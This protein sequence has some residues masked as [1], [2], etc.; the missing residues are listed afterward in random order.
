MFSSMAELADLG[1]TMAC[2][3][4]IDWR[5]TAEHAASKVRAIPPDM[6]WLP[7]IIV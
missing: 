5:C 1:T 7:D 6:H 2:D 4:V 3:A